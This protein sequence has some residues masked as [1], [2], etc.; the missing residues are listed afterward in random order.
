MPPAA[1]AELAVAQSVALLLLL[2]ALRL[3][4][5]E[6]LQPAV[7]SRPPATAAAAA[8]T[9]LARKFPS[10]TTVPWAGDQEPDLG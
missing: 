5:L 10:Q 7:S 3:L 1:E 9:C 2:L 8:M 4:E 6:E